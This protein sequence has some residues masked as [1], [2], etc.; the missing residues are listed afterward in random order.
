MP[1]LFKEFS[2]IA[3][4]AGIPKVNKI[5]KEKHRPPYQPAQDFYKQLREAIIECHENTLGLPHIIKV[6]NNCPNPERRP[7]YQSLA[8]GYVKWAKSIGGSWIKPSRRKFL[9]SGVEIVVN[10]ELGLSNGSSEMLIKLYFNQEALTQ[11]RA[12]FMLALMAATDQRN[13]FDKYV[14][15]DVRKSKAFQF[16]GNLS[17]YLQ[18]CQAEAAYIS[19]IWPTL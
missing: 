9:S 2:D 12:N 6:A 13:I 3:T 18:A 14:V 15:L 19:A 5:K 8:K 7:K 4:S 17:L 1:I 10:P 11:T 16:T